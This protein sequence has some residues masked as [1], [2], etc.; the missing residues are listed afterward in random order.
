[1]KGE[2]S[3]VISLSLCL[4]K[5]QLRLRQPAVSSRAARGAPCRAH[6]ASQP[7]NYTG[8]GEERAANREMIIQNARTKY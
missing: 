3:V 1:M 5:T 2:I 4:S 8:R 7:P 6:P